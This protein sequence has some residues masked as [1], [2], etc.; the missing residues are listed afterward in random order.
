MQQTIKVLSTYFFSEWNQLPFLLL[1]IL[2]NVISGIILAPAFS[3][4]ILLSKLKDKLLFY[5][6][7]LVSIHAACWLPVDGVPLAQANIHLAGIGV[8]I[9]TFKTLNTVA[10]IYIAAFELL[11]TDD[12]IF[13]KY[14]RRFI[15][16]MIGTPLRKFLKGAI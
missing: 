6:I 13:Q 3:W 12:N 15:P 8:E 1:A 9:N 4:Q 10:I 16:F 11:S 2:A 14:G 7:A 5:G